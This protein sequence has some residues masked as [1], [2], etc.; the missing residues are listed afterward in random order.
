[1][2]FG[3]GGLLGQAAGLGALGQMR[4]GAIYPVSQEQLYNRAIAFEMDRNT[5]VD[6]NRFHELLEVKNTT[7]TVRQELQSEINEWLKDV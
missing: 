5:R 3:S 6:G 7:K 4:P 2:A 1:M